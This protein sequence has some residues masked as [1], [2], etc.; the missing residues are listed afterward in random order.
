MK[1]SSCKASRIA[2][3]RSRWRNFSGLKTFM[4]TGVCT[5]C[6][7]EDVKLNANDQCTDCAGSESEMADEPG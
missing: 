4:D 2:G 1:N 3:Q 5:T 6:G 7:A